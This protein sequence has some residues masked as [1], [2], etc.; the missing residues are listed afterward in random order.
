MNT[1]GGI[2]LSN[3][4]R[5]LSLGMHIVLSWDADSE[6]DGTNKD[7]GGPGTYSQLLIL[8]EYMVRLASDL[9]IDEGDV[10]P[11]DYFDLMGGVGFGGYV[12]SYTETIPHHLY[13]L[14]AILLGHLRMNVDEAIEALLDLALAIFP[15]DPTN[16]DTE[17][18]TRRLRESVE[19]L[20]QTREVPLDRKMQ[21][22]GEELAGCKVYVLLPC[23]STRINILQSSI[24][25]HNG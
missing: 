17:T 25:C 2:G 8:K 13:R 9:G 23:T 18:R 7:S 22:K 4:I 10:Y 12:V 16:T 11:A 15:G 14:V 20:L 21:D 6:I 3:G 24:R 1:D 5:I 19:G